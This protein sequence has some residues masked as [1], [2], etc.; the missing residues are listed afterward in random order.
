MTAGSLHS[1]LDMA[2][3]EVLVGRAPGGVIYLRSPQELGPHA[4]AV[5]DWLVQWAHV[6]P[7]RV[8]LAERQ[9]QGDWRELTYEQA[10]KEVRSLAQGLL[11]AGAGPQHP[12]VILSGNS[13]DHALLALA[14]MHVGVPVIPVSTAYSLVDR[15]F[16]K[17][18]HIV[19]LTTP[20]LVYVDDPVRY[21]QA[22]QAIGREPLA[23]EQLRKPA[24]AQV[25]R[26]F[27]AIGPDTVAKILFTSGS[28]G[29]P[30]GVINTHRML[31][32]NQQQSSQVWRFTAAKPPVVVDWL[33]WNHT[34]GGNYNFNLVLSNGGTFY[35]DAGKPIPGQF[36][37]SLRNLREVAPTMYFNVP[38]GFDMLLPYLEEDAAFRRHFF[39][40]CEFIFYAGAA[41]PATTWE[42]LERLGWQERDGDLALVSSWGATETSPMCAGAHAPASRPGVVGLPVP[43]CEIKLVPNGSKLEARVKG[44]HITPGYFRDPERTAQAFDGEGYYCIGDALRFVEATNPSQGLAFDGRVAEDFKLR[45]GTWVSV[46]HLRVALLEAAGALLQD[47]AITGHDRDEVG[48]LLFPHPAAL[49]QLGL[50]RL[51]ERIALAMADCN[52]RTGG[53]SSVRIGRAIVLDE[54][55]RVDRGEMTDKGYLNQRAVLENRDEAVQRLYAADDLTVIL[56]A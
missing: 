27:A 14:A 23:L 21:L 47:A 48:A 53:A 34:F 44:P 50:E 42:R 51:R 15:S 45:S 28:T 29:V 39:S 7:S 43:G 3:T 8:F 54:P 10:L 11:D 24:T 6:A 20:A 19:D 49:G 30:K 36:E 12:L 32:V 18:R 5:G 1:R 37:V 55:P 52:R 2:R 16:G 13:I 25:D 41:L 40:R 31:T 22:L 26:A 56:P 17:L 46:G 9:A 33:P 35:I 38:R 4:R